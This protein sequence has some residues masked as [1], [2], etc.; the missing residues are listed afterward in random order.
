MRRILPGNFPDASHTRTSPGRSPSISRSPAPSST[1]DT[2]VC[3]FV[4]QPRLKILPHRRRT[5][6]QPNIF[7]ASRVHRPLQR[8]VNAVGYEVE[9]RPTL[10]LNR[11][12]CMMRQH[13][14]RHLIDRRLA[15]PAPPT[16]IPATARA[17][18]Q[19]CCARGS[20]RRLPQTRAGEV[21]MRLSRRPLAHHLDTPLPGTR[22]IFAL[23]AWQTA[24][25]TPPAHPLPQGC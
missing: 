23:S 16:L 18:A 17:P 24:S 22:Q 15:P 4:H 14:H 1:G 2:T 19:T 11:R 8:R 12:A 6:A 13:K 21:V 9:R 10:H 25:Q 5:A 20:T 7:P 3:S